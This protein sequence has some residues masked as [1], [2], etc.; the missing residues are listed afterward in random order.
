MLG[1]TEITSKGQKRSTISKKSKKVFNT[2]TCR[3]S[4]AGV[5]VNNFASSQ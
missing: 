3:R 2:D 4:T 1:F 5:A